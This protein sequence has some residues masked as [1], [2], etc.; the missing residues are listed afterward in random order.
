MNRN[1]PEETAAAW[2]VQDR[3]PLGAGKA[4]LWSLKGAENPEAELMPHSLTG[5]P[6]LLQPNY[7]NS[8]TE[9]LFH[10]APEHPRIPL[11]AVALMA[12]KSS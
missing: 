9:T 5:N 4:Q 2:S 10:Q 1:N 3:V 7:V 12:R 6:I 11:S 8:V